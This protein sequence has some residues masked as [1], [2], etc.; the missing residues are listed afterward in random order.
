MY[1]EQYST[2]FTSVHIFYISLF[3]IAILYKAYS[4]AFATAQIRFSDVR[5]TDEILEY[6][7]LNMGFKKPIKEHG[8][9]VFKPTLSKYIRNFTG[10]GYHTKIRA[11]IEGNSIIITSTIPTVKRLT[12]QLKA[13]SS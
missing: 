6:F 9:L 13:F 8:D 5:H 7:V 1:V 3:I 4:I 2:H 10:L 11:R 12:K